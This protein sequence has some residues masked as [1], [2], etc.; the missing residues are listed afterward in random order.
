MSLFSQLVYSFLLCIALIGIT[1]RLYNKDKSTKIYNTK[2]Y[3]LTFQGINPQY[4][5]ETFLFPYHIYLFHGNLS[6]KAFRIYSHT[7][8][9]LFSFLLIYLVIQSANLVYAILF[10][11]TLAI[12]PVFLIQ[13]NW[14]GF[15]EHL[16]FFLLGIIILILY[17][18][19]SLPKLGLHTILIIL[20]II[21][22]WTHFYQF[23]IALILILLIDA[24]F[25][26]EYPIF[27]YGSFLLSILI[28]KFLANQLFSYHGV[29]QEFDRIIFALNRTIQ[30]WYDTHKVLFPLTLWNLFHGLV[31][32][33][34]YFI[35]LRKDLILILLVLISGLVTFFTFDTTRVFSN[36]F[37]P[38]FFYYLILKWESKDYNQLFSYG[39]L[40]ALGLFLTLLTEP[41][42]IWG[43][44]I[45]Y[46]K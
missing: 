6:S 2:N 38:S 43:S 22:L 13:W 28:A 12:S 44:R 41:F 19:E 26:K 3:Y 29:Y 8:F 5:K 23:I 11:I 33:I 17:Y 45:I 31:F 14:I 37:Y 40:L 21:G 39:I 1:E 30:E 42:Y 35:I 36:L 27:I 34:G 24:K 15:P 10:S 9:F 7:L 20:F 32:L 25:R 46:L 4:D 16:L 18:R